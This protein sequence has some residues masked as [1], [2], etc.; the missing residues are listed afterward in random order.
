[1]AAMRPVIFHPDTRETIRTFPIEVRRALGKAL[2]DLQ[3]GANLVMPLSKSMTSVASGV[4]ELRL[5]D[6]AGIY[7]VF[8]FKKSLKGILVFHAFV[9]KT[10]KTPTREIEVG[11]RRLA[12]VINEEV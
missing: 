1:M 5:K 8:Y 4:E 6:A 7:R 12:E 3:K 2:T 9:K 10:Q 11:K